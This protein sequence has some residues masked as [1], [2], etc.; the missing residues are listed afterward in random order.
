MDSF[1]MKEF[2]GQICVVIVYYLVDI[3]IYIL[4]LIYITIV[5]TS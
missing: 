3:T 2:M 1:Q 4:V 5:R